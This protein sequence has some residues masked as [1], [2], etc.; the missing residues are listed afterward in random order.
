MG[1]TEKIKLSDMA[2]HVEN[3]FMEETFYKM[4][5]GKKNVSKVAAGTADF[6]NADTGETSHSKVLVESGYYDKDE[7][8]K[9]YAKNIKEAYGLS[10]MAMKVFGYIA[11]NLK[12]N[13]GEIY[14]FIP[15]AMKWCEYQ[16]TVPIYKGLAELV[17][18]RI[19]AMSE[20]PNIWYVNPNFMFNGDRFTIVRDFMRK[21]EDKLL[22]EADY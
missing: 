1:K 4:R 6:V 12:K 3:P 17:S 7:F 13:H 19:I 11:D 15:E 8:V 22:K 14:L 20:R 9:I 10:V 5:I 2:K 18:S 21:K 16:T